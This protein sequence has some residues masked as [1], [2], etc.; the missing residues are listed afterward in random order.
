MFRSLIAG[1]SGRIP[2]RCAVCHLWPAQPVCEDCVA[3][4][5]QPVP[6]CNRCALPVLAGMHQCGECIT[7]PPAFDRCVAAVNY[8]YPWSL[9]VVDFKFS[10]QAAWARSLA[11]LLRSAPWAEP[12]LEQADMV[13]PMPLAPAR[14][15]ERGFNQSL[16]LA[17]SL[18]YDKVRNDLLLRVLDTRAQSALPRKERLAN[19]QN[20]FA[21]DPLR[22]T[23]LQGQRIVLLDDVMTTGASLGAAA[24]VLR[25]AGASHITAM[26]FAR[27]V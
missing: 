16:L 4:F 8:Q 17:H 6:R 5:A 18:G 26:V 25:R 23:Q 3:E 20:A 12:A 21:I 9:L 1:F 19:V 7:L 15:Q 13:I 10:G 22:H 24:G 2:S 11:G 27:T 14:L